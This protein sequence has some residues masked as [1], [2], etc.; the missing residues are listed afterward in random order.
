MLSEEQITLFKQY[1]DAVADL[2]SVSNADCFVEGYQL[3]VN[4]ILAAFPEH[5]EELKQALVTYSNENMEENAMN[6]SKKELQC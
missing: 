2:A 5:V 1:D 3:G 6:P 4:L